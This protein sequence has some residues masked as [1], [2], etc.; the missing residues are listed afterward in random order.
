M[1]LY[2]EHWDE[3][4]KRWKGTEGQKWPGDE[5][6]DPARWEE[7]FRTMFVPFGVARWE[8]ALEIG[9]GGGKYTEKVLEASPRVTVVNCDVSQNFLDTCRERLSSHV[10]SKRLQLFLIPG[11]RADELLLEIE[12]RG[13]VRK[14]DGFFSID[15]MVHVDLQYLIA[16][17]ITAALTLKPG[18]HLILTL[19]D[20]TTDDGFAH[21]VNFLPRLYPRQGRPSAK[22]E[23]LGPDIVESL[24]PRLGF[25][26]VFNERIA[27]GR[28]L[29]IVAELADVA[30]ADSFRSALE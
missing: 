25:R 21:L 1:S 7:L 3:H 10:A 30:L 16:Y 12:R 11:E 28:D 5:W 14:L 22:F 9:G 2:R 27:P 26:I 29:F 8:Q 4:V 19:A 18:G 24:L 23:F 6:G 20:A 17:L 15:A 13:L